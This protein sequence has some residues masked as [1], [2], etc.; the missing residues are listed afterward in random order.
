M[1]SKESMHTA[2]SDTTKERRWETHSYSYRKSSFGD[3]VWVVFLW[4][5]TQLNAVK[6]LN[7]QTN[8][9][10]RNSKTR[11]VFLTASIV[12]MLSVTVVYERKALKTQ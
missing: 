6:R 10:I 2:E 1:N 8:T 12:I 5:V 9:K 4:P 7:Q 3:T 11:E